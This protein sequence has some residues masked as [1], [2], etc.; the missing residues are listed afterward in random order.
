MGLKLM[1]LI[2]TQF[3]VNEPKSIYFISNNEPKS[4]NYKKLKLMGQNLQVL[5]LN[6]LNSTNYEKYLS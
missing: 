4:I 2:P 1:G 6:G 5:N 3:Y